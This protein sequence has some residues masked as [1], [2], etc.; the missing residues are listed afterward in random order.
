MKLSFAE[1][2]EAFLDSRDAMIAVKKDANS[3]AWMRRNAESNYDNNLLALEEAHKI[4][5]L[6]LIA[7]GDEDKTHHSNLISGWMAD[8]EYKKKLH[9]FDYIFKDSNKGEQE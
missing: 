3:P 7:G 1:A 6:D 4:S 5:L 8:P 2:L 9:E